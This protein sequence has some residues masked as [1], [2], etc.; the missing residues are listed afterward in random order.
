MSAW[1]KPH[2]V[3]VTALC[4]VV[5]A[6]IIVLPTSGAFS[7]WLVMLLIA[8]LA[9]WIAYQDLLDFTIPD[10]AVAAISALGFAIRISDS[11]SAGEPLTGSLCRIALDIT[12]SGGGLLAIREIY[13]RSRGWDGLGFGDVKLGAAGGILVGATG[14]SWALFGASLVAIGFVLGFQMQGKTLD[15]SQRLA[16]GAILAPALWITWVLEQLPRLTLLN[17]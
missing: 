4:C 5:A 1:A 7:I 11:Y 14:F 2:E 15:A 9:S 8:V 16:F 3:A 13:F 12:L 17:T 10:N 6:A